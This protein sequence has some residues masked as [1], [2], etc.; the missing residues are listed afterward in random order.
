MY[1]KKLT[2]Y[3]EFHQSQEKLIN[4]LFKEVYNKKAKRKKRINSKIIHF[5]EFLTYS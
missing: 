5:E 4:S 2:E 1:Q 3:G